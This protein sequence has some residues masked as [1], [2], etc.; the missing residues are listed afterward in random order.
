MKKDKVRFRDINWILKLAVLGGLWNVLWFCV[1][2]I[3][4]MV[5]FLK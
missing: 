4:G 5:E 2:V 1:G 3:V